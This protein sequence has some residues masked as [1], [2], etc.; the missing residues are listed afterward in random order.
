MGS[1]RYAP[2]LTL[3]DALK[4]YYK[5]A[6]IPEDGGVNDK[7]IHLKLGPVTL[8]FPNIEARKKAVTRH[9]LH[10][11]ANGWDTSLVGEG[12]VAAWEMGEGFGP[13]W[14]G[15]VLQPQGLWWGITMAPKETFQA[16][17]RGRR[18]KNF[19]NHPLTME[20]MNKSVDELREYLLTENGADNQMRQAPGGST[21]YKGGWLDY[22][23]FA[24]YAL[25]GLVIFIISLPVMPIVS[26]VYGLF[27][28][29][30]KT[31]RPLQE[32]DPTPA[33]GDLHQT[34]RSASTS[35]NYA[36]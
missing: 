11:I 27:N 31:P 32:F 22:L 35:H 20:W 4:D 2:N 24:S 28:I 3:R 18:N 7:W 12:L 1:V 19:Y 34:N 26:L 9:D 36:E 13:Y 33:R 8:L 10:H 29:R 15:W 21:H 6:R 25:F 14:I 30:T 5:S 17:L 23:R 16:Y